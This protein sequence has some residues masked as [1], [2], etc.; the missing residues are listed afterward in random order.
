L[1]EQALTSHQAHYRSY[2]GRFLHVQYEMIHKTQMHKHN[3]SM[4]SEI[5]PVRQNSIQRTVTDIHCV[6]EKKETKT[7]FCNISYKIQA[8][9]MKFCTPFTE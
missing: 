6:Q 8:I 1:I 3:E 4:H 2:R 5:D 9:L 7:F